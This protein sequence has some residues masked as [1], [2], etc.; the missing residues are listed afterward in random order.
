MRRSTPSAAELDD[1]QTA[2]ITRHA[3]L[4]LGHVEMPDVMSS[5]AQAR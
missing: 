3:E 2:D 1:I 5:A 4:L